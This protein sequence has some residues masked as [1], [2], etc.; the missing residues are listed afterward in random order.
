M[1]AVND[2][3]LDPVRSGEDLC[4]LVDVAS[5]NT[6]ADE[7]RR[8]VD[9]LITHQR[10]SVDEEVKPFT[11]FTERVHRPRCAVTEP[12]VLPDGH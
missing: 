11:E 1:I 10:H 4:C 9:C 2:L 8:P 5:R 12:E 6:F 3:T 7:S